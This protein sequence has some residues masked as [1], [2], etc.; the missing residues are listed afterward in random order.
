V[1]PNPQHAAPTPAPPEAAQAAAV[2]SR[3]EESEQPLD[4]TDSMLTGTADSYA[5]GVT[6]ARG[7]ALHFSRGAG[8]ADSPARVGSAKSAGTAAEP[9][10][11]RVPGV[12]GGLAWNC[13]FPPA[14]D[15]DGVDHAQVTIR[16]DVDA[17]GH[18]TRVSILSDPGH[19]FGAA[20]RSCA[21]GKRWT[22]GADRWGRP[23]ASGI[24]LSVRFVR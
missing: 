23:S 19:G 5:G 7:A 3:A 17:S 24:N 21:L 20:A 12:L 18:P 10:R 9:D 14:A 22:P 6:S 8:L 13:P 11:S 2:L 1:R 16:V 15:T 4:L